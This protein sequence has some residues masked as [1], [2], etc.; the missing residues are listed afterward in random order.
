[1]FLSTFFFNEFFFYTRKD[2]KE[3]AIKKRIPASNMDRFIDD[4]TLP[5][6]RLQLAEDVLRNG[7]GESNAYHAT[8]LVSVWLRDDYS[9]VFFVRR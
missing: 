5:E 6:K 3:K 2:I 8:V 1:M 4:V 7:Y 9:F